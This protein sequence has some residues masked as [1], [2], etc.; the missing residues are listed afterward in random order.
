MTGGEDLRRT[1]EAL[2]ADTRQIISGGK[3]LT[4]VAEEL[5]AS[6]RVFRGALP[7]VLEG[8]HSVEELEDSVGTVA[9]TVEPLQG[10]TQGVGRVSQRLARGA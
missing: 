7:Q 9:D 8:L 6:L 1:G 10:L 3:D 5:A 4:A 2:D